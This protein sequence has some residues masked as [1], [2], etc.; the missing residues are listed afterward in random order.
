MALRLQPSPSG[1][2][3]TTVLV[4]NIH[5]AS[6]L[7]YIQEVL[8]TL[9][10]AP[11]STTA[12]YVSHEVTIVHSPKLSADDISRALSDAAF[13]VQSV[14]TED[15]FGH[16]IYKQDI[17]QAHQEWLEQTAQSL[18]RQV[19]LPWHPPTTNL[20]FLDNADHKP[21]EKHMEHCVTCQKSNQKVEISKDV[22]VTI[23]EAQKFTAALSIAGMTCPACILS[24]N[25]GVQELQF[26]EDVNVSLL[27]NSATV[28]FI[29]LSVRRITSIR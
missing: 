18:S 4:N 14:R 12:N 21:N 8:S 15:D 24:I 3:T 27:T 9:Q 23:P 29:P 5:C 20:R 7:S 2:V 22:I 26:L 16:I 25:E 10:P 19:T 17:I 11:L 28:T 6:C 1:H 13:E